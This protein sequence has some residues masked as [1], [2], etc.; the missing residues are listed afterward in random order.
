MVNKMT[1]TNCEHCK[2]LV[3]STHFFQWARGGSLQKEWESNGEEG[4][5]RPWVHVSLTGLLML[6]SYCG[7][8]LFDL[9]RAERC[10]YVAGI[11]SSCLVDAF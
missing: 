4:M 8:P 11:F 5:R 2:E 9:V 6:G 10:S 1:L 3:C 7:E